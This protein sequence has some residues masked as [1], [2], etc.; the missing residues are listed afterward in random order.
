MSGGCNIN[1]MKYKPHYL[2]EGR[3]HVQ[4][5][6]VLLDKFRIANSHDL[7]NSFYAH[8]S[9]TERMKHRQHISEF[10]SAIYR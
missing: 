8:N 1:I 2:I 4:S 7:F 10:N 9:Y 3:M 6:L 5:L